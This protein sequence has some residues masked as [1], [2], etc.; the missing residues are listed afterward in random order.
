MREELRE[1]DELD[2]PDDL[3]IRVRALEPGS[4]PVTGPSHRRLAAAMV[5]VAVSVAS[6]AVLMMS[7]GTAPPASI[8]PAPTGTPDPPRAFDGWSVTVSAARVSIGPLRV[9]VGPVIAAKRGWVQ[10][11]LTIEN[12]GDRA[13][14]LADRRTSVFVGPPPKSLLVSDWGCGYA[15]SGAGAPIHPGA[16]LSY[17]DER[18]IRPGQQVV[19]TISLGKNL[20]GMATL[21]SGT[22]VFDQPLGYAVRGGQLH[23]TSLRLA[24]SISEVPPLSFAPA[25]GWYD[26]SFTQRGGSSDPSQAWTSNEPLP[27]SV[28]PPVIPDPT[29]LGTDDVLVIVWQVFEGARDPE[30][31]NFHVVDGG[32]PLTEPSIGY[33]GQ[34]SPDM[35][36]S[37]MLVQTNG[38]Y[39]QVQA[40]FGS[41][42]PSDETLAAAQQALDRLVVTFPD[43]AR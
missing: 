5:A 40:Y 18:V 1:L 2:V 39:L 20:P 36:R 23:E 31:P 24:Y 26:R 6:M 22:Y 41:A 38:R 25:A 16:C 14:T 37:N 33:M 7:F 11:S 10:H 8:T 43:A 4:P 27:A 34:S 28:R 17:L 3:W 21:T 15:S 9:T 19:R 42:H 32:I 35:S 13:V 12:T 30:N 29:W